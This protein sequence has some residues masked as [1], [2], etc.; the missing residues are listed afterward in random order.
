MFADSKYS[1]HRPT[2]GVC[3]NEDQMAAEACGRYAV[4]TNRRSYPCG[5]GCVC[6]GVKPTATAGHAARWETE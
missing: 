6:D 4:L 5:V 2:H 3:V 1:H